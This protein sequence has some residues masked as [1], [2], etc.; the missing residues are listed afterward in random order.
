MCGE[1]VNVLAYVVNKL[2]TVDGI[3]PAKIWNEKARTINVCFLKTRS[4]KEVNYQKKSKNLCKTEIY[5][6]YA[7]NVTFSKENNQI[8]EAKRTV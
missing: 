4:K 6:V 8:E 1:A 7:C 5:I 3:I 2:L